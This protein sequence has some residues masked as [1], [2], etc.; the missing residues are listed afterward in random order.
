MA[1]GMLTGSMLQGILSGLHPD[2]CSTFMSGMMLTGGTVPQTGLTPQDGLTPQGGLI[3]QLVFI[4][5]G[6]GI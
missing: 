4:Q 6:G 3:P 5:G 2:G 1:T